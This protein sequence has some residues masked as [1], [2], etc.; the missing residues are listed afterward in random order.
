LN[1]TDA[2]VIESPFFDGHSSKTNTKPQ[3]ETTPF[4]ATS[5][6]G[7]N[8]LKKGNEKPNYEYK[9]SLKVKL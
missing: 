5:Q 8:T 6:V 9:T 3:S 2:S 7:K 4:W 1:T